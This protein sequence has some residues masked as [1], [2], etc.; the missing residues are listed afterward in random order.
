MA[1]EMD[2]L[3]EVYNEV[4]GE[5]PALEEDPAGAPPSGRA[6]G[7]YGQEDYSDDADDG[8]DPRDASTE[9]ESGEGGDI[10]E[11]E[12]LD[13]EKEPDDEEFEDIPERLLEAGRIANIAERDIIELSETHPEVLEA[14]ARSQEVTSKVAIETV[15]SAKEEVAGKKTSDGFEPVTLDLSDEEKEDFG[16]GA[17]KVIGTLVGKVNELGQQVSSQQQTTQVI[18]AQS[19]QEQVRQIDTFFDSVAKDIPTLGKSD[20][21]TAEQKQQR[22]YAFKIARGSMQAFGNT[23][24]VQEALAIG[25]NALRGQMSNT[26]VK[27]KIVSELAGNKKRFTMRGSS[28]KRT[29]SSKKSVEERSLEQINRVLDDPKYS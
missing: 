21:L 10:T 19:E 13:T 11:E 28:R 7:A 4:L 6:D 9:L 1:T 24:T 14:L 17:L 15:K 12:E 27:A 2:K 20:S 26:Q 29:G 23:L 25:V 8:T 3:N 5:G 16:E 18:A 22:Q